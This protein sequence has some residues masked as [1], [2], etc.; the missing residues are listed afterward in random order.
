M[1]FDF[2]GAGTALITP[3]GSDNEIDFEGL[4]EI[5]DNQIAA[6]IDYLVVL[7]TTAE[8]P[9]L[10]EEEK[11]DIVCFV[12]ER[13]KGK[14]PLVVGIG[15]NNTESILRKMENFDCDGISAFLSVTPYYNKPTQEGLFWHYYE[16]AKRS[17]LPIIL[18]NVPSRT[19]VNMTDE[20]TLRIASN[21]ENIIAV[22]EAS[23]M[24][25][26]ASRILKY[27]PPHFKVISGDD[28]MALPFMSIGGHGVISVIANAF[29]QK[30]SN[31]VHGALKNDYRL[32]GKIHLELTELLKLQFTD[33]N[34]AGIKA[35]LSHLG[36]IDNILRLPL[37][38]AGDTTIQ[39]IGRELKKLA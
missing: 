35:M 23:G 5:V 30:L 18:Y 32:A 24:V 9:T 1:N 4:G 37:V 21:C 22:K 20:T 39:K 17:V 12:K 28:I 15:G 3:F 8:T 10:S 2:T 11:R 7:G 36:I 27:A 14:I 29:P 19:G 25:Q 16:L 6:G 38:P 33:G 34:P 31:M 13:V 26:Q